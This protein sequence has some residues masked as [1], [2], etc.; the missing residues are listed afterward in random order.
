MRFKS[1][2]RLR[3]LLFLMG[4]IGAGICFITHS[5]TALASGNDF[6]PGEVVVKL[7]SASDLP[8]VA[9]QYALSA[10]PLDQFGSRPIYRLKITDGANPQQK[11]SQLLTDPQLRV[12]YAEPNYFFN[13]PEANRESWSVGDSYSA[14]GDANAYKSQWA[15]QT[16]RLSVAQG[17]TRGAGITIAVLDTG[18]DLTH[19]ALAGRLTQGYDFVDMDNNPSEVGSREQGPYG[20]GTHVAGIIALVAPDAKIMPVRVLDPNGVGNIWVLAEALAY[21][22]D[23]DGN[24]STHDGADVINIS[25][26]TL[27]RTNLLSSVLEKVCSDSPV[28]GNDDFPAIGNPNVVVVAAAGNTGDTTQVYPAAEN[29]AGLI[30]VGAS[31]QSDTLATFSTRGSWIPVTAPGDMIISS[32]PGGQYGTWRGTSMAAPFVAGEAALV[33]AAFT[34]LKQAKIVSHIVKYSARIQSPIQARVD[35]GTTLTTQ[36]EIEAPTPTPTPG[37]TPA[38][39]T[40]AAVI[41]FASPNISVSEND[42]SGVVAIVVNRSGDMTGAVSADFS[43]SDNS[44]TTPCQTNG[45]G[46]ASDRCDYVT[47]AGTLRFAPGEM[48]KTIL[49][50]LIDDGYT[51]S[52]ESFTVTLMNFKGAIAGTNAVTTITITDNDTGPA[53]HN[54]IDDQPFF[55]RMQ[56]KDFLGREAE[57][58]GFEFWDD[59]MTNCPAGQTCDRIDTSERF[60][61][62]D[63]FNERGFYVFRLYDVSLGKFPLYAEFLRDVARLNGPQ[64]VAEQ[65]ASKDAYLLEFINRQDFKTL[66]GQYLTADLSRATDA[67]GFVNALSIRSGITPA[68][69]QSLIENLQRASTDPLYRDP[70]HTLEDFILTPEI[71]N[72]GT[73][74]YDRARIVMQYFGYLRRDPEPGGFDFWWDQLTNPS[75]GHLRDYRFMVGGFIGSDE[76]RFRFALIPANP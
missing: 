1:L 48:S 35:L 64:T 42:P 28:P 32:V 44:G 38:P 5:S 17:V 16:I 68:N 8:G 24:P 57:T 65:R 19:P 23:P 39:G 74:Y 47:A 6:V 20:H 58:E 30:S 46:N 2:N 36:P 12:V 66:Y 55:I 37:A 11:A 29:I 67:A 26:G 59:R 40:V 31:T 13:P 45:S 53:T 7:K 75:R 72:Q 54:P 10:V 50:P 3:L 34:G 27:R 49:I 70:A 22:A 71:S 52:A 15:T 73:R 43:T 41:Q 4:T 9:S 63:E 14:G 76:Y 18:V 33:R 21:A 69:R 61:E 62:S 51:E 56:Y 25:L 60:F